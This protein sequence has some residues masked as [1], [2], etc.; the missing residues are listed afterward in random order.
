MRWQL[1]YGQIRLRPT[2]DF[3]YYSDGQRGMLLCPCQMYRQPDQEETTL[4]HAV[5]GKS[6]R[7]DSPRHVTLSENESS[8]KCPIGRDFSIFLLT[9]KRNR[10]DRFYM[11][12]PTC[13]RIT[14]PGRLGC[15]AG[16]K[17]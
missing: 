15:L 5:V 10:Q 12:Q 8:I 1:R 14:N 3:L 6:N 13:V 9:P 7:F 11:G 4:G 17:V 16:T 2:V